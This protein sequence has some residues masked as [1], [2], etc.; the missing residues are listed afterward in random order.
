[1]TI[2]PETMIMTGDLVAELEGP[3]HGKG[4]FPLALFF[5]GLPKY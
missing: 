3:R 2:I 5:A 4:Y 1:M